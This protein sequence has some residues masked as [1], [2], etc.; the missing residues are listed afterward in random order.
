M[1][2]DVA[3]PLLNPLVVEAV[4]KAATQHRGRAWAYSE[5]TDL[6]HRGTH[7]CGIFTGAPFS[8]F[9]KLDT[10]S[11]GEEQFAA[12]LS[13]FSLIRSRTT[14]AT[15]APVAGGLVVTGAGTLLL[16]EALPERGAASG[17][18]VGGRVAGDYAAIGHVLASLHQVRGELFGLAEFDGFFGPLPQPN[19][20][21]SSGT[22]A[23][24]YAERRILPMLRLAVDSRYLPAGLARGVEQVAARLPVLCGPDPVPALLHG[25]AQQNNFVS[26]ADG[27]VAIDVA[28][29]FGHPEADLAL[30][31]NYSP[32]DPALFRTYAESAPIDPGF[33]ERRELW[34]LHSYLAAIAF[35]GADAIDSFLPR[36][37]S[38]VRQYA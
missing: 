22:W 7:P 21:V 2:S 11:A 12:E 5:F 28:P 3:H 6:N 24:F 26:T 23:E 36:L 25:D 35:H 34:R 37:E 9:A 32:V 19:Q 15:P 30:V 27:A 38:A 13:G 10:S 18:A 1:V 29:Y 14:V 8:V 4:E 33:P 17:Q 16:S 31:D 20:P